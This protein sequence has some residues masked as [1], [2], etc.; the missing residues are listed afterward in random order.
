MTNF[1]KMVAMAINSK[2]TLKICFFR[3]GRPV[4]LKFGMK[5]QGMEL[6]KVYINHDPGLTLTYFIVRST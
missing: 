5:Y 4:I 6:Y 3:T 1:T 2:K